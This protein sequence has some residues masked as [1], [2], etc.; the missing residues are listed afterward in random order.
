MVYF[1]IRDY[2]KKVKMQNQILHNCIILY[3]SKIHDYINIFCQ[4]KT[5]VNQAF[6]YC[7]IL[8]ISRL[9]WLPEPTPCMC[10]LNLLSFPITMPKFS[11]QSFFFPFF[12]HSPPHAYHSERLLC[13]NIFVCVL[14]RS[15]QEVCSV[16]SV[17][18]S[19]DVEYETVHVSLC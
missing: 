8:I 11:S 19:C 16:G 4:S 12:F 3:S 14:L 18:C 13:V 6:L 9:C 17:Q 10:A 5:L 1:D 15:M 2:V 7:I